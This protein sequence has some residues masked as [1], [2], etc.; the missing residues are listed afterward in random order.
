MQEDTED[1]IY[2]SVDEKADPLPAEQQPVSFDILAA[3]I[4]FWEVDITNSA[5]LTISLTC[6]LFSFCG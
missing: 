5:T 6:W 3:L 1:F 4:Q 2:G